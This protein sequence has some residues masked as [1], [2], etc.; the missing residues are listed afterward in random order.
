MLQL[1]SNMSIYRSLNL[2][3]LVQ[4][5]VGFDLLHWTNMSNI[6]LTPSLKLKV[7]A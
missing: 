1:N 5:G 2:S 7:K 6:S 4:I 3:L